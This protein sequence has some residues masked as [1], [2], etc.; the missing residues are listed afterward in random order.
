[1]LLSAFSVALAVVLMGLLA[2]ATARSSLYTQ[3]DN[4][5]IGVANFEAGP[6]AADLENMG[7]L[8]SDALRAANVRLM[9]VR[10]DGTI[11]RIEGETTLLIPGDAEMA[12]ARTQAGTSGRS[13]QDAAGVE[14]RMVAVPLVANDEQYALVIARSLTPTHSTLNSM[15]NIL[16]GVGALGVLLASLF[17]YL[18]GRQGMVPVRQLSD[19]VTRVTETDDLTP[20]EIPSSDELG[21]LTRSFNTMLNSLASSRDRQRR[22]IAD[23]GHELRTPLTSMRTNI[24]LLVADDQAGMLPVGAR[25]EI[26]RD[27]AAQLGEFTSLVGDLVQ[28]SRE[29]TVTA[30]PEPLDLRDVVESAIVRAKRR[31]PNIVFDVELSPLFIVGEPDTLERAIT[32]L[33][34]NAVKFSPPGGTIRV[35]ME[36]DTLRIADQGPGIADEDL[37]HV[38]DR[39]YRSDLSRNT[40]GTGLGLSIVAHTIN[41]HGGWVKAGHS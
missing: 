20:I 2:Y 3:L 17:G 41:G 32:N 22:L 26:L 9:L 5:L 6:I 39:F 37:P 31:G 34:D 18:V 4:E 36:G 10:S 19:A 30:S 13:V 8:D 16:T 27:I 14:Y 28:L 21:D 40:P 24:E 7:G 38:F 35:H 15:R 11:R 33:L 12:I 25:G 1:M 23:A 29:D